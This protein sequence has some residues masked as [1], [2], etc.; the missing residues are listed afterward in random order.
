VSDSGTV[1]ESG[2]KTLKTIYQCIEYRPP[3]LKIR[4]FNPN[5]HSVYI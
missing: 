4:L 1:S 3:Y 2:Y 5:S